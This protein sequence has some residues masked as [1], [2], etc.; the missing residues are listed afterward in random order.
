MSERTTPYHVIF[1][2]PGIVEA[3]FPQIAEALPEGEAARDRE[4][5]VSTHAVGELLRAIAPESGAA[6]AQIALLSYHAF[7]H[8]RTGERTWTLD[9]A[10]LGA[11][12]DLPPLGDRSLAP[13]AE[14]GYCQLP[15]HRLW[16]A[17]DEGEPAQPVD[18]FFWVARAG[19]LELLLVLG[20]HDGRDGVTV[21]ELTAT[22]PPAGHWADVD[23]RGD[24]QDFANVLPG[25]E[26]L[27]GMRTA[28][29]AF[30]L[31]SRVFW[32]FREH[33]SIRDRA[34]S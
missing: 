19:A 2:D 12:L 13:P 27:L 5:F 18:G 3:H 4:R 24:G 6:A 15:R 34:G 33:G 17:G 7:H 21:I 14:A 1:R 31:A 26:H 20:M 32:H 22:V 16:V 29:E 8:W 11:L 9:G 30:K 25:G 28:G 23:A 10:S